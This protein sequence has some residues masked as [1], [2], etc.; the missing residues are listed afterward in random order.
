MVPSCKELQKDLTG[1]SPGEIKELQQNCENDI[2][3]AASSITYA[4]T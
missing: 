4:V 1:L 3:K 2:A